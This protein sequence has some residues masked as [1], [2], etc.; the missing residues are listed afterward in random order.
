MST[1][2]NNIPFSAS[3]IEKY[4]KGELSAGEMHDLEQAA[5]DDPFLS[6]AI[7]GLIQH[8]VSQ[9][10][11]AELQD[12]LNKK[13]TEDNR[14]GVILLLRRR[15]TLAAALILLLGIGFTFFYRYPH[16]PQKTKQSVSS[17]AP[18]ALEPAARAAAKVPEPSAPAT[19][20]KAS[21][22]K[23]DSNR[24]AFAQPQTSQSNP[25]RRSA[26]SR[27]KR[28]SIGDSTKQSADLSLNAAA[29]ME[30]KVP[31]HD[32][33]DLQKDSIPLP[34]LKKAPSN[35]Q[36]Y[37]FR[38]T[39]PLVFSGKVLDINYRPLAGASITFKGNRPFGTTTDNEGLFKLSVPRADTALQLTV[40]LAGYYQ[41]SLALNG[42]S[43]ETRSS[44]V[45]FLK[46]SNG[47]LDEVV[48][49]GYGAKRM[50]TRATAPTASSEPL[51][52]NWNGAAPVI[53]RQAY[54]QYLWLSKRKLGLD[55]T[56]T[57]TETVSF[58]VSREGSL[59]SFKI[60]QSL[61]PAHDAA[62]IRLITDGPAW[63]LIRG[64]K[65]RAAVTVNF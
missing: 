32:I 6:D 61:S 46:P 9:Q 12:R 15:I 58:I 40:S 28:H 26:S 43:T 52:T 48:V 3:D 49:S 60:E 18:K 5:L 25:T 54:L 34:S 37:N 24:I 57:G 41:T 39:E 22:D 55:S 36:F 30:A 16:L 45:I 17:A 51:D 53:G 4:R 65:V 56:V 31:T 7:D 19:Q 21:A 14:R 23:A 47:N 20:F 44:H 1:N 35:A 63:H 8:P 2:K 64:K 11:L 13:V 62:I 33:P 50:A 10:D 59:S 42:L 27:R 38:P 29:E